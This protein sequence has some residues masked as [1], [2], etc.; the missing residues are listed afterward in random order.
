MNATEM[1][2]KYLDSLAYLQRFSPMT[3]RNHRSVL[4][5]WVSFCRDQQNTEADMAQSKDLLAWVD[6]RQQCNDKVKDFTIARDLCVLR[7]FYTWLWEHQ[8]IFSNPA[9]SLPEFICHPYSASDYLSV[10]E[11]F[12]ILEA[13]DRKD[14]L[15]LRNYTIIALMWSTGLRSRELRM[16]AWEDVDLQDGHIKVRH[17][18]GA[19]QRLIFL[20]ERVHKDLLRY[21]NNTL[22]EKRGP[23]FAAVETFNKK[24]K[25]ARRLSGQRLSDIVTTAVRAAGITR[26][27][28]P[29][30]LR[31][32][33][34]THMFEAG[35][36]I[37]DLKEIMG[38]I[39]ASETTRYIH[40]TAAAAKRLLG[41]HISQTLHYAKGPK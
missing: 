30:T 17:G 6:F 26:R 8:F 20:N 19:K 11:C 32:T 2:E 9:Q 33:F 3:L 28:G 10:D 38:H 34:A 1:L 40:V 31:H 7:T 16:M 25:G 35:V 14:P 4:R 23:L 15:A 27:I 18:K 36:D 29:H 13:F 21:R 41:A 39:D 5:R 22:G 37:N 12:R 24:Q